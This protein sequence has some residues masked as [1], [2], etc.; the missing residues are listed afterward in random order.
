MTSI[1]IFFTW[2]NKIRNAS[3]ENKIHDF[4]KTIFKGIID[5]YNKMTKIEFK[6]GGNDKKPPT[7]FE[8]DF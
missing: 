3:N 2:A 8:L 5:R 1:D 6:V 7:E 4:L